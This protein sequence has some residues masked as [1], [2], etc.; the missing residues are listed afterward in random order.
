MSRKGMRYH[1]ERMIYFL[2]QAEG[3]RRGAEGPSCVNKA[4][5]LV[6]SVNIQ[7]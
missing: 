4:F 6:G 2:K 3:G 5:T 7:V 1:K